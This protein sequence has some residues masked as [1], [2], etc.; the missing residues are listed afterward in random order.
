[1]LEERLLQRSYSGGRVDQ[2]S[3]DFV[4]PSPPF[5]E[6]EIQIIELASEGQGIQFWLR[7]WLTD[8]FQETPLNILELIYEFVEFDPRT[9]TVR[10][11]NIYFTY[12]L[13]VE[14]N[15]THT[16]RP[17]TSQVAREVRRMT[18]LQRIERQEVGR[19]SDGDLWLL[20]GIHGSE[21]EEMTFAQMK[22]HGINDPT[23]QE[24]LVKCIQQDLIGPS[25]DPGYNF[26]HP[27]PGGSCDWI[28]WITSR[29]LLS[30]L[31]TVC[32]PLIACYLS[33]SEGGS[34]NKRKRSWL[35]TLC[36]CCWYICVIWS[37]FSPDPW[38]VSIALLAAP[39]IPYM[40]FIFLA[41][42][43]IYLITG[44]TMSEVGFHIGFVL[45]VQLHLAFAV[46]CC[47]A[48]NNEQRWVTWHFL[49]YLGDYKSWK[50][51]IHLLGLSHLFVS[52]LA[53]CLGSCNALIQTCFS[54]YSLLSSFRKNKQ[55]Y[56]SYLGPTWSSSD[57]DDIYK[58]YYHFERHSQKILD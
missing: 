46:I 40:V 6:R 34:V 49:E 45:A 15:R 47:M 1:M 8:N 7:N 41:M 25:Y 55:K 2:I 11:C 29:C 50:T 18:I 36:F 52:G 33:F 24:A 12:A 10:E 26:Y 44:E 48:T 13:G 14:R 23:Y 28:Q 53:W 5:T 54:A 58:R 30:I 16:P 27:K 4:L 38:P 57:F 35:F 43:F 17:P 19:F 9:W 21:L 22:S 32:S 3:W 20:F 37:C 39:A 56:S 51:P 31:L 42:V